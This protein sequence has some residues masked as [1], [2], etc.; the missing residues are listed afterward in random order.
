M[1][2]LFYLSINTTAVCSAVLCRY[3]VH[4]SAYTSPIFISF[5]L[6]CASRFLYCIC[7]H[8]QEVHDFH[9]TGDKEYRG[10]KEEESSFLKCRHLLHKNMIKASALLFIL[11]CC[12]SVPA[13][14][15]K[16]FFEGRKQ[17]LF[18][19]NCH[20]VIKEVNFLEKQLTEEWFIFSL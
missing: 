15:V 8:I 5:K 20:L 12:K 6:F 4:V 3:S 19:Q 13:R 1:V 18:Q 10:G 2:K 14:T 9:R 7:Q 11:G 17:G 16:D